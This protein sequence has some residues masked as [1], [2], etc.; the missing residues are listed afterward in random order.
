[1]T[2]LCSRAAAGLISRG[3]EVSLRVA[4]RCRCSTVGEGERDSIQSQE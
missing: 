4:I 3:E 1:M 2:D